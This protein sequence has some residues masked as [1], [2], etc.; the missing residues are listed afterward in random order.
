MKCKCRSNDPQWLL[1]DST[2]EKMGDLMAS[3]EGRLL[4]LYDELS[5]FLTQLNL[6]KGKG[7][8]V[9]HELALFLQLYNGHSWTRATG[10]K[11]SIVSFTSSYIYCLVTGDANFSMRQ[12]SLTVGGFS[13]P[14]VARTLIEQNG[15]AEIGLSQ[16][17]LW[18][19]PKPSFARFNTLEP[20]NERFTS[21]LGEFHCWQY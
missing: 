1:G 5:T 2:L 8:N 11:A 14:S 10:K 21:N 19:F 16:R 13:Q 18:L 15:S 17:F 12:T 6:Y 9:S 4:G 7:V 20:I 3:N